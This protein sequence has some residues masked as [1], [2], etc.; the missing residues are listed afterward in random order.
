MDNKRNRQLLPRLS[1][2]ARGDKS[3]PLFDKQQSTGVSTLE[4]LY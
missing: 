2:D 3:S 1:V 4:A